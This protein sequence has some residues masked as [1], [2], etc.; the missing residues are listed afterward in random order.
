M[1]ADDLVQ[2]AMRADDGG[3]PP[4]RQPPRSQAMLRLRETAKFLPK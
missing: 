2:R 3:V 4:I 1:K